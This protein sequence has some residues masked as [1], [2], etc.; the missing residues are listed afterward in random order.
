M[1]NISETALPRVKI[2]SISTLWV[3][4]VY[5]QLLEVFPMA[6]FHAQICQF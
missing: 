6:N 4:R 2:S 1:V 3:E 5:L